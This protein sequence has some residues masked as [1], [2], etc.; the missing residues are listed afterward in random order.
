MFQ[1]TTYTEIYLEISQRVPERITKFVFCHLIK[2]KILEIIRVFFWFVCFVFV[3]L[4][5]YCFVKFLGKNRQIRRD[6][7][8]SLG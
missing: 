4:V 7:H 5:C 2:R 1:D 8:P 3:F 6:T